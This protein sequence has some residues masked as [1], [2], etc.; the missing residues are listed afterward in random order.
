MWC[1][2][3]CFSGGLGGFGGVDVSLSH[4]FVA[5]KLLPGICDWLGVI[6]DCV[7]V[8]GLFRFYVIVGWVCCF[9]VCG[10]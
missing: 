6:V 5:P 3:V 10:W 7:F 1:F 9:G 8:I 4:A 2:V